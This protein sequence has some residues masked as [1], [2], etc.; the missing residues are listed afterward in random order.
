MLA[1]PVPVASRVVYLVKFI[2][3]VADRFVVASSDLG[4]FLSAVQ[5]SDPMAVT[6]ADGRRA[7]NYGSLPI[8]LRTSFLVRGMTAPPPAPASPPLRLVFIPTG[9]GM[10]MPSPLQQ[11][12]IGVGGR[13]CVFLSH[14]GA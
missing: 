10:P 6:D 8:R 13:S 5:C 12:V 4:L 14:L 2:V 9:G 1:G 11:M 3:P 7:S